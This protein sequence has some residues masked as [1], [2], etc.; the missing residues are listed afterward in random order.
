MPLHEPRLRAPQFTR[1]VTA[2]AVAI[3]CLG[4][5][6]VHA[7]AAAENATVRART[8]AGAANA[9]AVPRGAL[10]GGGA[11]VRDAVGAAGP[12]AAVQT[13]SPATADSGPSCAGGLPE[14]TRVR[15]NAGKSTLVNLPEPVTRRTLGDPEIVDGRMVSPAV[16]YL[17]AGRIGATNAILQGAS[18]RCVVLD[19]VVSIDTEAVQAKLAELLPNERNI[20]VSAAA[21]SLVLSGTVSDAMAAERA[22]AIANAFIRTTYQAGVV[23]TT[24]GAATRT[25]TQRAE[26]GGGAP[27]MARIVNLLGIEASQQVMLEVK[28]AEVSKNLLDK[29][30]ARFGAS[31]SSGSWTYSILTNFLSNSGGVLGGVKIGDMFFE[32]DAEKRDGLVRILAEPNLMAISGQEGSFLAGG[33][34]LI[35]VAQSDSPLGGT[36]RITLEEKDFGVGLKFTP[37]VLSDGRINLK[38]APEVSELSRE[39]VGITTPGA[40]LGSRAVFPLITTRRAATTVQLFDGQS[41]AIG[42]LIKNSSAASIKAF[43]VLGEIPILGALFRSTDFQSEKTE[44]VF[45]VTPRL[46]KPIGPDY[47]LPTDAV[48]EPDRKRLFLDGK[49][50][51]QGSPATRGAPAPGGLELK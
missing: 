46:V 5:G 3:G 32:I 39:G 38:V 14:P 29:L 1:A 45:I 47:R 11:Q 9:A 2:I 20:R 36:T 33:Q 35:P 31:T 51:T 28:V 17:T 4:S 18:G 25:A 21:D 7:Q 50:D 16:L 19:I 34:I 13:E 41:F 22:V 40:V 24:G 27:L 10:S 15:L 43:P 37:T 48:G 26:P 30:G 12:R 49:L 23:T 42:G 8:A 44:L 6:L